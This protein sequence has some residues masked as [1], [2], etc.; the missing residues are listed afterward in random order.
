MR[1]LLRSLFCLALVLGML[2]LCGEAVAQ[3]LSINVTRPSSARE[4]PDSQTNAYAITWE[5][6]GF[7]FIRLYRDADNQSGGE[8]EITTLALPASES[9]GF[10]WDT[11]D[12]PNLTEW[13][14]VGKI[15][16]DGN[17]PWDATDRSSGT[18]Y[19]N[20]TTDPVI[21]ISE[22]SAD[23]S[24]DRLFTISFLL[25][26]MGSYYLYYD[27][28]NQEGGEALIEG[29][30][31]VASPG[32]YIPRTYSW[33]TKNLP[34]GEK[35]YIVG[36][37]RLLPPGS[38]DW[39]FVSYSLGRVV[40]DHGQEYNIKVLEPSGYEYVPV[41]G[42]YTVKWEDGDPN[43]SAYVFIYTDTDV[44][45]DPRDDVNRT[46]LPH[47]IRDDTNQISIAFNGLQDQPGT[48]Y[49]II[50]RIKEYQTG[51]ETL[52]QA[53]SDGTITLH[54]QQQ[55]DQTPPGAVYDLWAEPRGD[56]RAIT[57]HW[58]APGDDGNYGTAQMY[59]IRR[60]TT[61][62]ESESQFQ[63]ATSISYTDKKTGSTRPGV[64][65][66]DQ[67][68]DVTNLQAG[69]IYYF[70]LKSVDDVG[71]WSP[72]SNVAW[73]DSMPVEMTSFEA[74][75]GFDRITLRWE[76]ASETDSLGWHVTRCDRFNGDFAPI[77]DRLIPGAGTSSEPH[78]Y[79]YVDADVFS[80][81]TYY[82]K[83]VL[84]NLDGSQEDSY[85]VSASL[86]SPGE[87]DQLSDEYP[88]ILAG[89]FMGSVV[90]SSMGGQ[91]TVMAVVDPHTG[92]GE[93]EKVEL[94][95]MGIPSGIELYDDGTH[96][97]DIAG[98]NIFHTTID[99]QP[100]LAAGDYLL[101]M[102]A[103]DTDG[104]TSPVFPYVTVR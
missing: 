12:V 16:M 22:P 11:S 80:G 58:T 49:Y 50:A 29:P 14:I 59:D 7:G 10:F 6:S 32:M 45:G 104:N 93:I 53:Y 86:L 91:L 2:G 94:Y 42:T 36:K 54:S 38:Q 1:R 62:I 83:L 33:E 99:V 87:S 17:Q 78:S 98:D 41:G 64:S 25:R 57:L 27:T 48:T 39:A 67:A 103:T 61:P 73:Q 18:V 9:N 66:T 76:T 47:D 46:V 74:E 92:S 63:S 30:T 23:T 70:A 79:C 44:D 77:T 71:L 102:V 3:Q 35:Y 20:R 84:Y 68:V 5:D 37:T 51:G 56:G 52:G 81:T 60:S 24:A 19:I 31:T 40:I 100:G 97:D 26:G 90:S 72:I 43:L 85:V 21:I 89:G 96:G 65:G 95:Y 88:L 15:S 101:S 82:Y 34:H 75:P 8:I 69:T 13:Y 28:D 4:E 55:Q